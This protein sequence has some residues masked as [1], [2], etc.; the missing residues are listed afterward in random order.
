M[1]NLLSNLNF[2]DVLSESTGLMSNLGSSLIAYAV[3]LA[4]Q[5]GLEES[6]FNCHSA[7]SKYESALYV[8][9]ESLRYLNM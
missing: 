2:Q 9:N 7:C 3:E 1:S 6:L 5:G 8:I 4:E